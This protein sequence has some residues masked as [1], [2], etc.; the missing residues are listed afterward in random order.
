MTRLR[1]LICC[2]ASAVVG[3]GAL[4]ILEGLLKVPER[5]ALTWVPGL[6][7]YIALYV[8]I[9][10]AQPYAKQAL[11]AVVIT[12][13]WYLAQ[14]FAQSVYVYNTT[15]IARSFYAAGAVGGAIGGLS[16]FLLLVLY[17]GRRTLAD[18]AL[19]MGVGAAVGSV[20]L[21]VAM[22]YT[23]NGFELLALF[24]PWQIAMGQ[25]LMTQLVRDDFAVEI[26][27]MASSP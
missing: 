13:G 17:S 3:Y 18:A 21:K 27:S 16:M 9:G 12:A 5:W 19:L 2:I 11:M 7:F 23:A 14:H 10:R 22:D 6:V 20:T 25:I 1:T 8:L 24:L 4:W 26:N 15:T